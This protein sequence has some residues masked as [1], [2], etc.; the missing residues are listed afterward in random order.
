MRRNLR[1]DVETT[2]E[3]YE[4]DG[5]TLK[6][7]HKT[8]RKTTDGRLEVRG[9]SLEELYQAF[10]TRYNYYIDMEESTAIVNN[11]TCA[12]VK[13]SPKPNLIIRKTAD[14]FINRSEGSVYINLDNF[15]IIRIHGFIK[16]PFKFLFSWYFVPVSNVDV[17]R[18]EFTVEYINFNNMLVEQSI[19]GLADYEI[20]NR[21]VEKFTNKITNHRMR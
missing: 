20:I 13:F 12:V 19:S 6:S 1:I 5:V 11:I 4:A 17:Y 15:E 2:T 21:G 14:Q 9:I 16:N 7:P 3:K 10:Q 18:F 8:E